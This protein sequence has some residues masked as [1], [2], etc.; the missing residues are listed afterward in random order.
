MPRIVQLLASPVHRYVGRPADGPAPAPSGELV[1]EIRIRAGLGIVGDRY[2]GKQAHRDASV[3]V[4]AQESLPPGSDL[5]QVRRNVLT[6]GIAVDELIGFVLTL[7]S[8][9]G[10]VHLRVRRP[11]N[12]C[13][14]MDVAVGPGAWRALRGR[15]G[16]RCVP[17][18][19]GTLP[20]GPITVTIDSPT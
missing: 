6:A 16:V 9:Q 17:L 19:D 14:W 18:N 13:A 10:P 3:T 8:G 15:G 2:F 7:D 5:V 1:E 4:I 11:A 12:P 20:I